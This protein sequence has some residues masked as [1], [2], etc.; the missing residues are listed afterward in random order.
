ML[1]FAVRKLAIALITLLGVSIIAFFLMRVVPGDTIDAQLG[2]FYTEQ[3]AEQMRAELGLDAPVVVQYGRWLAGAVQGD[4]GESIYYRKPVTEAIAQRLPV[5]LELA[6]LALLLAIVVGVPLGV[7]AAM[8]RGG[9]VD[10]LCSSIGVLGVSVPAFWLATLLILGFAYYGSALPSGG[11]V[12][13]GRD[14]VAN[15][16][17]ML[18]P[19][20]ALGAAVAAVIIRMTR[21]AMLEVLGQDYV[22]TARAKGVGRGRVVAR[23]ALRNAL[24]PVLTI[25]GIQAGYL[26]GGSVVIEMVFNLPGVGWAA[27]KAAT[28]RDY[29]LLQGVILLIAFGF[30]TINLIVDLLYGWV[31]PR[32][33]RK[34][35]A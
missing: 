16:R 10:Y 6:A 25:I 30:V 27:Y 12:S 11:F 5:T 23:H 8:R 17:H 13:I 32:M 4:L 7:L 19:T 35:A 18:L 1:A 26:L 22:R 28:E 15:L 31:D 24:V 9:V 33:R 3:R 14:P 2:Q 21:S 20:L 34:G 29:L